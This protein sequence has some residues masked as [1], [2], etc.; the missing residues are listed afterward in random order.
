MFP[1]PFE[2]RD[3]ALIHPVDQTRIRADPETAVSR[4]QQSRD[5]RWRAIVRPPS[6]SMTQTG[7]HQI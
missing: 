6:R 7:H 3:R 4:G 1:P 5:E 2:I